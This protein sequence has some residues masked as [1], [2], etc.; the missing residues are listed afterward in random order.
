MATITIR[1]HASASFAAAVYESDGSTAKNLATLSKAWF[2]VK[3]APMVQG[4][5]AAPLQSTM[6]GGGITKTGNVLTVALTPA[7]TAVLS[8]AATYYWD[9]K[10]LFADGT[11]TV[12]AGLFGTVMVETTI[13][14]NIA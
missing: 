8:P 6:A 10:L 12:P 3:T 1:P 4:D 7:Q 14:R 11:A 13:T 9:L 5:A 2:T